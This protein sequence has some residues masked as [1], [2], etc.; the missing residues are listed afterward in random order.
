MTDWK[1]IHGKRVAHVFRDR[2]YA[3]KWRMESLCHKLF[4]TMAELVGSSYETYRCSQCQRLNAQ[5]EAIAAFR[6]RAPAE[7]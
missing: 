3:A 6:E 5:A 2:G 4:A 1:N 7:E